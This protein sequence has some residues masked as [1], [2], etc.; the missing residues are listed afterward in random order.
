MIDIPDDLYRISL[1]DICRAPTG[2]FKPDEYFVFPG[3]CTPGVTQNEPDML[4]ADEKRI[5]GMYRSLHTIHWWNVFA[6]RL[7]ANVV[8]MKAKILWF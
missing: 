8:S 2:G 1:S 4:N 7:K 5:P 3:S 6:F